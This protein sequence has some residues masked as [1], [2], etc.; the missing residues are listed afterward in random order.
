MM[1]ANRDLR[2]KFKRMQQP[3]LKD[4][5]IPPHIQ[6]VVYKNCRGKNAQEIFNVI[7]GLME[8]NR[9]AVEANRSLVTTIWWLQILMGND[10]Y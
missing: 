1:R 8:F 5:R 4:I 3:N 9:Q 6:A 2:R 10:Y 7:K